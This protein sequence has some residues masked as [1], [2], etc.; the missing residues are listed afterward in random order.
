VRAEPTPTINSVAK[1]PQKQ[2]AQTASVNQSV[3]QFLEIL[4]LENDIPLWM[5]SL[6]AKRYS[7]GTINGD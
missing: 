3:N 1:T 6:K 5:A 7:P 2:L 4:T